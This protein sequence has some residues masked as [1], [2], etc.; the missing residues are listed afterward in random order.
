MGQIIKIYMCICNEKKI[1]LISASW[2][3]VAV[4]PYQNL[5][6]SYHEHNPLLADWNN[7]ILIMFIINDVYARL[8]FHS[9]GKI[10]K[11]SIL[12]EIKFFLENCKLIW[13]APDVSSSVKITKKN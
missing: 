1:P 5:L 12:K 10:L 6:A 4:E 7:K 3:F 9:H 13:Y 11:S 8:I 2:T